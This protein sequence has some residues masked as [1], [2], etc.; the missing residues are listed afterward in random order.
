[1]SGAPVLVVE[2]DDDLR[3]LLGL[4]C[5]LHGLNAILAAD[6]P[7][8]LAVID[9]GGVDLIVMDLN[10]RGDHDGL[11]ILNAAVGRGNRVVV[12]SASVTD[13]DALLTAMGAD[14]V[15]AKP[16]DVVALPA[17]IEEVRRA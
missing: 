14:R 8:A 3:T 9:A 16:F 1:M 15:L 6:V 11:E 2:D 12:M 7:S 5:E 10:L 4:V 13:E 17:L